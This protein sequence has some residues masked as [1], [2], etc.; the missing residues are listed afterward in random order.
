M[1]RT[2]RINN[3]TFFSWIVFLRRWF[4]T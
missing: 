4:P 3:C 1:T 2:A